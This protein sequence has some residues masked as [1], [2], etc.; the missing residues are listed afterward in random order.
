LGNDPIRDKDKPTES[1]DV[2]DELSVDETAH[3]KQKIG[4]YI[5]SSLMCVVDPIFWFIM[6]VTHIVRGPWLHFYRFLCI[7][8]NSA[9]GRSRL[10]IVELVS[11]MVYTITASFDQL[12]SQLPQWV[13]T[14]YSF[15][16]EVVV[17]GRSLDNKHL[18]TSIAVSLMLQ[19]PA[20][21][22]RR[23][24]RPYNRQARSGVYQCLSH[25]LRVC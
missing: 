16:S 3:Y 5:R 14:A 17:D 22:A 18:M 4:K 12:S 9:C 2:L 6:K 10:H 13:D 24:V 21:F 8:R 19:N 1:S 25:S 23:V 11:R 7:K 15:A 20:S